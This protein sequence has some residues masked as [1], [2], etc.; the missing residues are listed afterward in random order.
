MPGP[1]PGKAEKVVKEVVTRTPENSVI[2]WVTLRVTAQL[3]TCYPENW[4]CLS[5]ME[6][7]IEMPLVITL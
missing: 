7:S 5:G 6:A 1:K 4:D 3:R 2:L